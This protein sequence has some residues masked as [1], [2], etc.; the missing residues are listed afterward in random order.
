V[1]ELDL[2]KMQLNVELDALQMM[3]DDMKNHS[4]L[5]RDDAQEVHEHLNGLEQMVDVYEERL[6]A[7]DAKNTQLQQDVDELEDMLKG[8]MLHEQ[9]ILRREHSLQILLS[10][11]Q[12]QNLCK[13]R[14]VLFKERWHTLSTSFKKWRW[15]LLNVSYKLT[16]RTC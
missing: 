11:N 12:S 6:V 16:P 4:L 9:E 5:V 7:L 14:M 10:T 3:C 1:S 2:D 8:A 13:R 15:I